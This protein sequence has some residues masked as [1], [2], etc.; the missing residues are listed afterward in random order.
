[1]MRWYI[2]SSISVY[3]GEIVGSP[4]TTRDASLLLEG[5]GDI[6]GITLNY[7]NYFLND[8]ALTSL[9]SATIDLLVRSVDPRIKLCRRYYSS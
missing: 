4:V 6:L 2:T 1:M 8:A 9:F 5:F 7:S 3:A